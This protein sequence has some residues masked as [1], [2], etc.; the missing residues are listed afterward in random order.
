M[1]VGG[2]SDP[3]QVKGRDWRALAK[4]IGVGSYV[5]A[6]VRDLAE[7]LRDRARETV[8]DLEEQY[9]RRAVADSI[10]TVIRRRARRTSQ[11]LKL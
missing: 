5:E 4:T 7:E 3:G 10:V 9:G 2:Q 1:K 11:L 6:A 8:G